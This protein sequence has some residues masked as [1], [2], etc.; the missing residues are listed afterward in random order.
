MIFKASEFLIEAKLSEISYSSGDLDSSGVSGGSRASEYGDTGPAQQ[1]Q[2]WQNN[3][4]CPRCG[5]GDYIALSPS[6]KQCQ[7]CSRRYNENNEYYVGDQGGYGTHNSTKMGYIKIPGGA[8]DSNESNVVEL[9]YLGNELFEL[10]YDGTKSEH[11]VG[12]VNDVIMYRLA[13]TGSTSHHIIHG[14]VE[15]LLGARAGD[16]VGFD[17]NSGRRFECKSDGTFRYA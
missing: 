2:K 17:I 16:S 8:F 12:N 6:V 4:A 5:S 10:N 11:Q 1:G 9:R 14:V 7:N 15:W 3:M 13:H